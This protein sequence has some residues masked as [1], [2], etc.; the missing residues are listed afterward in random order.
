M[1]NQEKKKNCFVLMPFNDASKKVY[2]EAIR[3]AC[4]QSG[5][6]SLRADELLGSFNISREII[7]HIFQS[8]VIVADLTDWNP[9]VFYQL[10]VAHAVSNKVIMIIEEENRLPFDI[11]NYRCIRYQQTSEGIYYLREMISES[12]KN[13]DDWRKHPS[14]PVQDFKPPESSPIQF[15]SCFICYSSKDEELASQLHGD[16]Q[17]NGIRCW[18]APENLKIGDSIRLQ[19]DASIRL[20]DKMLLILS[21]NS[22]SS[23]WIE[24]EIKVALS[25]EDEFKRTVL[26]PIRIDNAVMKVTD[27]WAA[28]LLRTRNIGDFTVW[29]D[30][31]KYKKAFSRL[32]RALTVNAAIESGK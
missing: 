12:L 21:E 11:A 27:S 18:F 10:G 20:Y 4:A 2:F 19:I 6:E 26:F 23:N 25:K 15:Y 3:P 9:N 28:N 29:H 32:V 17:E 1:A 16:L 5:F 7:E 13:I 24:Y 22:V 31:E 14:N 8:E 30:P